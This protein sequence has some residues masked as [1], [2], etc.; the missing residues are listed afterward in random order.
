MGKVVATYAR[1]DPGILVVAA[2]LVACRLAFA[3]LADAV[4]IVTGADETLS[5]SRR[6]I[7]LLRLYTSPKFEKM[8]LTVLGGKISQGGIPF[9]AD[10]GLVSGSMKC[11]CI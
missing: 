6:R 2:V 4:D 8:S 5:S 9:E 1:I 3:R 10:R 7:S 11:S